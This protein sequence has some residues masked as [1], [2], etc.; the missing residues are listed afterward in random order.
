[1]LL[2][3]FPPLCLNT[4][5]GDYEEESAALLS[6]RGPS[7]QEPVCCRCGGLQQSIFGWCPRV[8]VLGSGLC[9]NTAVISSGERCI[10]LQKDMLFIEDRAGGQCGF[11]QAEETLHLWL[12]SPRLAHLWSA[13]AVARRYRSGSTGE[14][15]C[16]SFPNTLT[17]TVEISVLLTF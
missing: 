13:A 8:K 6:L 12:H 5:V 2:L 7:K 3:E 14:T 10:G 11:C 9:T 1:M 16:F 15:F 4:A 17:L